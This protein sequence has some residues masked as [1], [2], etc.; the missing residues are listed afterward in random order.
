MMPDAKSIPEEYRAAGSLKDGCL[1]PFLSYLSLFTSFGTLLCCALPS[2]M[3]LLGLGATMAS[4]LSAQPWL[5][6]LARHRDWTFSIS[7]TLIAADFVYIY[8]LAPRLRV[9]GG[10]SESCPIDGSSVCA[11]TDRISR[12]A[13][14][15]AAAV[16]GV[17]FFTAYVLGPLLW[18][19]GS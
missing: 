8:G 2:L 6:V 3:V 7:G 14:W 13:L 16:Y 1:A 19:F 11:K 18:K 5:V 15:V 9:Q 17:G 12:I 4:L 10:A